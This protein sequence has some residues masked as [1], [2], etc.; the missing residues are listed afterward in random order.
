MDKKNIYDL[1]IIGSGPAGLSASIYA[2]RYKLNHLVFG[3]E[4]G[5]Q[6]GEIWK[7]ENYPGFTS[8]SGGELI[9]KFLEHAKGLG[10]EMKS[11]SVVSLQKEKDGWLVETA[12]GKYLAKAIIMA[13][14]TVYRKINVPGEKKL[15]GKGVSYCATCDGMFFRDKEVV[16]IGG[17]NSAVVS[18]LQLSQFAKKIYVIYR[19]EKLSAEPFW[20]D[21]VKEISKIEIITQTNVTEIIGQDGV[22]KVKLDKPYE[23]KE[24]LEIDGVFVEI[25][26]DPGIS[27]AKEL[28]IEV[29]EKQFIKVNTDQGTNIEGVFAA[30]DITTGSNKFRQV[31][32]AAAEGAIAAEG[33][34]KFLKTK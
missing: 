10:G 9:Q 1:I 25:G 23:N 24:V 12:G 17:G 20:L 13:M 22:E 34:F 19:G 4:P 33:V 28:G 6:M 26:S 27:L 15:T 3:V 16:V 8:I 7:I 14:G 32:T 11:E 31:L 18:A 30:G 21:K 5:G 29:D 2:S